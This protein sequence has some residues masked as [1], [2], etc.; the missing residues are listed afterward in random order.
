MREMGCEPYSG[1]QNAEVVGIWIRKVEKT[2]IQTKYH[3]KMKEHEFLALIQEEQLGLDLLLGEVARQ[4]KQVH[5]F[6]PI[7]TYTI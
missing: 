4:A 1:E 7:C 2:I 5:D 6:P 3:R